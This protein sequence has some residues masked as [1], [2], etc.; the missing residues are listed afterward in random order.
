MSLAHLLFMSLLL[1]GTTAVGLCML[2]EWLG[3]RIRD[4]RWPR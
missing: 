3:S 4:E 2:I 1:G